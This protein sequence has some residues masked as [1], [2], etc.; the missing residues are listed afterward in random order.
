MVKD[1]NQMEK[2]LQRMA[3]DLYRMTKVPVLPTHVSVPTLLQDIHTVACRNW[4]LL[5]FMVYVQIF[6]VFTC[7]YAG[8]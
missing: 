3:K 1:V 7:S 6:Y 8:L 5:L 4:I 2:D